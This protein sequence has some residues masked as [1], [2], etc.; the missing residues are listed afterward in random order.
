MENLK[1]LISQGNSK[2]GKDTFIFNM[3]SAK[4]CPSEKLGL[5]ACSSICY[6]KK[7]ERLYPQV[8]PY[9]NRQNEYWIN[10]DAEKF[11]SEFIQVIARKKTKIK[12]LRFSESGDFLSQNCVNKLSKISDLL[13]GIVKVYTYTA[14]KDLDFSNIS[15]NL[16]VNG[17]G[18]MVSNNFTITKDINQKTCLGDC[19]KC[20]LCKVNRNK[21][22]Y[23]LSH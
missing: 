21:V 18:F 23:V 7:A 5:C 11:V 20:N 22:I 17:S 16:I 4:N 12:Y 9:R 3:S 19:S 1:N 15:D 6:A 8:L 14:R 2:I 10:T 13:K